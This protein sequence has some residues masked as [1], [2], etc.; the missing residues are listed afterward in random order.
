M[1]SPL[2]DRRT[3]NHSQRLVDIQRIKTTLRD[4]RLLWIG[5]TV[6]FTV[7]GFLHILTKDNEWKASQTLIVRD[8]AI[9]EI[10]FGSQGPLGRF[11]SMDALKR[12]L[13]TVMQV[14]KNREVLQAALTQVGPSAKQAKKR[15]NPFPSEKDIESFQKD[16]SVAA[17]KGTEFGASEVIYLSVVADD[18]DRAVLLAT[19]M[20]D[21]LEH[22]LRAIRNEYASSI[23]AE[24]QE[25]EVLAK[26]DLDQATVQLSKLESAFGEDLG[27][28]RTLAEGRGGDSTL[29]RQLNQIKAEIRQAESQQDAH[30]ELLEQLQ[31]FSNNSEAILAT[32]NRLLQSQPSL[33]RLKDGLV[34]AQLLTARLRGGLTEAHPRVQSAIQ[35]ERNVEKQLLD[36]V[37]NS[38]IGLKAEINLGQRLLNSLNSKLANLEQRLD[39]LASQRATYVNLAAEVNQKREQ[40]RQ[41]SAALAK[42]RGRQEAAKSSSLITRVD[43]PTTGSK[44]QGPGRS[45]LLLGSSVAGLAVGLSLVYLLAPW[46]EARRGR[47]KTD[48]VGRRASDRV[49]AIAADRRESTETSATKQDAASEDPFNDRIPPL[50]PET[51]TVVLEFGDD[52]NATIPASGTPTTPVR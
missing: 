5:P 16:V 46:Q 40:V 35:N 20:C 41:A 31:T 12:F 7:L 33:R 15:K 44:P 37:E 23:I 14:S 13:E 19:A 30:Q 2:N 21:E 48:R 1:N 28:M 11:D 18:P 36:E 34:D 32:P 9:G 45:I 42:S 50:P 29:Q 49:Q 17:P 8:E 24:L 25:K 26:V 39:M 22:R 38:I 51:P 3:R 10:S 27:E 52:A 6:V 47:R 4:N 43:E